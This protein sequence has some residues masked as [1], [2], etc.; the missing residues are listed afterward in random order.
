MVFM[1]H[2]TLNCNFWLCHAVIWKGCIFDQNLVVIK[3]KNLIRSFTN[4]FQIAE[5]ISWAYSSSG[6]LDILL[7]KFSFLKC[8]SAKRE[9][10]PP[11]TIWQKR[12]KKKQSQAIHI[13]NFKILAYMVP[14]IWEVSKAWWTNKPKAKFPP[15]F[16]KVGGIKIKTV[17]YYNFAWH[18]KN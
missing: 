7:T 10:T 11:W 3:V 2:W 9:L 8:P 14:K 18:F 17:I 12:K 5:K 4:W 1:K 6:S 16:F 13:Q 15:N